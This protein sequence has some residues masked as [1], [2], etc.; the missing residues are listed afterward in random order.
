MR[1]MGGSGRDG[2]GLLSAV[3][4]ADTVA[5]TQVANAE[6]ATATGTSSSATAAAA[7]DQ[8][9]TAVGAKPFV[10]PGVGRRVGAAADG[11]L[12]VADESRHDEAVAPGGRSDRTD[13]EGVVAE[14][15]ATTR[16][17]E[18]VGEVSEKEGIVGNGME[19][20]GPSLRQQGSSERRSA[21]ESGKAPRLEGQGCGCVVA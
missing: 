21:S 4:A 12:G 18:S 5:D 6:E 11:S 16:A 9:A 15:R 19:V 8:T 14:R 3:P 7:V 1:R 20:V 13:G 17:A 2:P 10:H